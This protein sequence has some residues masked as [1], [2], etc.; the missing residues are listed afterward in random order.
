V[1]VE[2]E[3]QEATGAML[4]AMPQ[5]PW[6][7]T[8]RKTKRSWHLSLLHWSPLLSAGKPIPRCVQEFYTTLHMVTDKIP[9]S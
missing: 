8:V 7:V 5:M 2:E 9:L 4:V 6:S 3:V 1:A